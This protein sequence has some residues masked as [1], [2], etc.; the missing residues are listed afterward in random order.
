MNATTLNIDELIDDRPAEGVFRVRRDVFR[1]PDVFELE[2]AHIFE[3]TWMY[4]GLESQISKP[5]DF[6]TTTIG[7]QPVIVMRDGK[8]KIGCFLNTCR[9]RGTIVCPFKSGNQRSHVCRYHGWAYNSAGANI[10]IT[11]VSDGQYSPAFAAD[12]HDLVRVPRLDSYRGLMFVS[13]SPDVPPLDQYLGEART[14]ID[15][16]VDQ[17]PSGTLEYIPGSVAYT[18]DANWKLQFEN[19]LDFYHFTS[20][21]S[22]YVELLQH[23]VKVRPAVTTFF[24]EEDEAEQEGQ[25]SF[26]TPY[27]HGAVWSI[28]KKG[29]Y[30]RPL[31]LD[32]AYLDEVRARVGNVRAKWMLRQ[33]NLTIFP[34]LQI[35]DIT[36]LQFRTWRPL[37]ADKT[38]MTSHCVG[39]VEESAESRRLRIRNYEDFFNPTGLASS[40]DNMMYEYCQ[41]G[42]EAGADG[43]TQGYLRGMAGQAGAH[44]SARSVDNSVNIGNLGNNSDNSNDDHAKR[45]AEELGMADSHRAFGPLSF[46]GETCFHAGYREWQRLL[47]RGVRG[48][49]L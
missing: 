22:S 20:T 24:T 26:S 43:W 31:N 4:V 5:H 12:N 30:S 15:L 41:A 28:R 7:R 29:R 38:E 17:S 2:M 27:G 33:R 21:H 16:V 3:A 9:H 47:Q 34:N 1:N 18:F 19:G 40:D 44:A 48:G 46:G 39:P 49:A 11:D 25:G 6:F 13:M 23:R 8:G 10:M 37:A 36:S 14:F 35:I 42:Y 45:Y 32:P